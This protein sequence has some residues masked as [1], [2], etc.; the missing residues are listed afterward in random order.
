MKK[1]SFYIISAFYIGIFHGIFRFSYNPTTKQFQV[2]KKMW[3]FSNLIAVITI[4]LSIGLFF[5]QDESLLFRNLVIQ[6]TGPMNFFSLTAILINIFMISWLKNEE[7]VAM[8]NFGLEL[9]KYSQEKFLFTMKLYLSTFTFDIGSIMLNTLLLLRS[10][11]VFK[12]LPL[13][14]VV[15]MNIMQFLKVYGRYVNN[16]FIFS[17]RFT[18]HLLENLNK[19]LYKSFKSSNSFMRLHPS[20]SLHQIECHCCQFSI[21]LEQHALQFEKIIRLTLFVKSLFSKHI[22]FQIVLTLSEVLLLVSFK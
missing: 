8:L 3:H 13:K 2:S 5:M 9:D 19:D 4:S 22:L 16:L 12:E 20:S 18:V 17:V 11:E 7:I 10:N 14:F 6:L 15:S 1:S 21:K